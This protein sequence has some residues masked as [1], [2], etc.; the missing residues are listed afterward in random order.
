M[1]T[2]KE[3][4]PHTESF[5]PGSIFALV[6]VLTA[7]VTGAELAEIPTGWDTSRASF[8]V[9]DAK[10]ALLDPNETV[11]HDGS[12]PY[13]IVKGKDRDR[14]SRIPVLKRGALEDVARGLGYRYTALHRSE[15]S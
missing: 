14:A 9:E 11:S 8:L 15:K 4:A 5:V 13:T 12:P 1:V 10:V 7:K 3:G 2:N 6:L